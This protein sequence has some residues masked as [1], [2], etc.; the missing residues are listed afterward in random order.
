MQTS[1]I[2]Y[3]NPVD[4]VEPFTSTSSPTSFS[5]SSKSAPSPSPSSSSSTSRREYAVS[6]DERNEKNEKNERAASNISSTSAPREIS[7]R[8]T[9]GDEWNLGLSTIRGE[10]SNAR[11]RNDTD[12]NRKDPASVGVGVGVGGGLQEQPM[13]DPKVIDMD[14]STILR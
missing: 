10:D 6:S 7:L 5:S 2:P 9:S 12:S 8:S 14:A 4:L 3:L 1:D 13:F 11:G